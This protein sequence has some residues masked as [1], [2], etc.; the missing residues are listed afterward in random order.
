VQEEVPVVVSPARLQTIPFQTQS[1]QLCVKGN[2]VP[3]HNLTVVDTATLGVACRGTFSAGRCVACCAVVKAFTGSVQSCTYLL[4]EFVLSISRE[5][6]LGCC[7]GCC[8]IGCMQ[9]SHVHTYK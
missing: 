8:G 7:E 2:V 4:G 3:R 9:D 5:G 6:L 1:S